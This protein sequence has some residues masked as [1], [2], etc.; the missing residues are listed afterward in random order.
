[1]MPLNED[2]LA[3]LELLE[4][5]HRYPVTGDMSETTKRIQY[6]LVRLGFSHHYLLNSILGLTALQLY[7]E[8]QSQT[9][10]YARAIAHQ[11]AAITRA[12]PH[13]ESI[14]ETQNQALLGFSAFTSMYAVAEPI[15]RPARIRSQARFDPIQ[16]LLNALHFSRSTLCFVQQNFSPLAISE[17]WLF[18]KFS[19]HRQDTLKDLEVRYPTLA[20]LRECIEHQCAMEEKAACLH[21]AK[22][23]FHRIATLSENLTD[24][25]PGKVIWG[26]GL[27]VHQNFLD[28]C[29]ARHPVALVVLAHFT[30][31]MSFYQQHWCV[32]GWPRWLLGYIMGILGNGWKDTLKWPVD[33]IFASEDSTPTNLPRLLI[34]A[35]GMVS[36]G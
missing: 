19:A 35:S 16:E 32:R 36:V 5:W 25:E 13:F 18:T 9:K 17:S 6:D 10:W 34:A 29:S 12:R 15:S 24:P 26:W 23:L 7:S 1:M 27:E 28:L 33:I 3:D 2:S 20:S 31:L 21:A 11:Q 14:D 8:D 4:H 30:V 22:A